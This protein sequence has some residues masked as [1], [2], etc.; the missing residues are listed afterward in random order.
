ML[1]I[2]DLCK[3]IQRGPMTLSQIREQAEAW[4]IF[5][6]S[7][8][9]LEG[10]TLFMI[11]QDKE[12][13]LVVVHPGKVYAAFEGEELIA[14]GA[15]LCKKSSTNSK[16]LRA[17]FPYT[18]PI[19]H[20]GHAITLGLGDRL[21]LASVGHLRLIKDYPV[22]P[23]LAQQ[24]IRELNLTNRTY[25][26]VLNAASWAVF[27]EGYTK[28]FG[29]DGDHLKTED[30]IYMALAHSFTMIT[31]D[32]SEH[33]D[34]TVSSMSKEAIEIAYKRLP[35]N[36]RQKIEGMF[37]DK[38][39]QLKSGETLFFDTETFMEIALIYGKAIDYTI[40][41][42]GKCLA[43]LGKA[44]DFEMSIDETL[45]P[46]TAESHF[47]VASLLIDGGVD[48]TSLAPRFCGEF[49]K[50]IDYIGDSAQFEKEFAMH[51]AIAADFGYKISV[52]SGSDKFAVFPIVGEKTAGEY[53]VKT[54]GTN[55]LEAM[56][57]VARNDPALYR[58]IHQFALVHLPEAKKYYHIGADIEKI[59]DI[60]AMSDEM[61]PLLMDQNHARQVIHITYGLILNAKDSDG[62]YLFKDRLYALWQRYENDYAQALI[63]HIGKHLE[64][65]GVAP[66]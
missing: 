65:L 47:F 19:S 40:T 39:F 28:G 34:N 21:G 59:G 58:E 31:L 46:T 55:W 50:G 11:K 52:H 2:F 26:E 18:A 60:M 66:V 20:K 43:S 56:R 30:E 63:V 12:S 36:Y 8:Q 22:F 15:K 42:Y 61:L 54:A 37:K 10:S 45:T 9:S 35:E 64:Y 24:S 27:Q 23:I 51:A 41:L 32:C 13:F 53:H 14:G 48:I 5:P 7:I 44:I 33:I 49:Q 16:V 6:N 57:V 25:D 62:R 17:H 1:K 29:A 4:G 38:T 3:I